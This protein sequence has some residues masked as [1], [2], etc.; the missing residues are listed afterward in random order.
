MQKEADLAGAA[1]SALFDLVRRWAAPPSGGP[2]RRGNRPTASVLVVQAFPCADAELRVGDVAERIHVRPST[3]S[4]MAAAAL[5]EGYLARAAAPDDARVA[6][7]R[8][9]ED[10]VRLRAAALDFQAEVFRRG[11]AGWPAEER[12]AFARLLVRFTADLAAAGLP[13]EPAGGPD[14]RA[15]DGN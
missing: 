13:P 1:G 9:T 8:L 4:R 3:A 10:G 15:G 2:P 11:T 6:G 7:L 14:V 5:G 12:A